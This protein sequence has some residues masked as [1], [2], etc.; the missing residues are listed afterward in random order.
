MAPSPL[1]EAATGICRRSASCSRSW[2][3]PAVAHALP[4]QDHRP[5]GRQQHIYGPDDAFRVRAAAARNI[6]A[7][8]LR[9]GRL[10]RRRLQKHIERHIEHD[11]PRTPGHHR[12]PRL[13][14]RERHHLAARRLEYLLAIGAHRG[15]KIG[16]IVPIKLL[17]GPAIEL[18]GRHVAR[19]RHERHRIEKCVGERDRQVGRAWTARGERRGRPAGHA[20][21]DVRHE[22]GDALMVHRDRLDVARSLEQ[23]VDELDVAVTAQ[24]EDVRNLL[25]DQIVDNDLGSVQHIARG[26][27]CVLLCEISVHCCDT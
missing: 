19:D 12:L 3:C 16:L 18:A 9:L 23:R 21:V 25:P 1:A 24:A 26:H 14:D 5:L 20:V 22:A 8:F 27:R 7:P 17:E 2:R 15:G 11:R 13:P 4:D 10:F 6:G